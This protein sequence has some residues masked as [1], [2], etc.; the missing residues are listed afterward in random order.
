MFFQAVARA[1]VE[2]ESLYLVSGLGCT[3][4][5]RNSIRLDGSQ[6][7]DTLSVVHAAMTSKAARGKRVVVFLNDADFIAHGV[8]GF[9]EAARS[10]SDMLVVYVN[11]LIYSIAHYTAASLPPAGVSA[12]GSREMPF[13][14]P[15]LAMSCG[16]HYVARWTPVHAKRLSFSLADALRKR[17]L[18]VVEVISPCLMYYAGRC[19]I[20]DSV[21]RARYMERVVLNHQETMENLDLRRS[22]K[23]VV[24]I[25]KNS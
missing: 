21:D 6:V 10:G 2:P 14:I 12:Y 3:G 17:R 24:G 9:V 19:E 1:G 18:S 15:M 23:I 25:F 8:D 5:I 22:G 13:N 7:V 11:S 16:A 20:R 4:R